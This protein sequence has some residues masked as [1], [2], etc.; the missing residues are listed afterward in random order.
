MRKPISIM[1]VLFCFLVFSYARAENEPSRVLDLK[2]K[3]IEVQNQGDL[4]IRG[5]VACSKINGYGSYVPLENLKIKNG[6]RLLMYFEPENYF[7][8][9][10]K[11]KYEILLIEDLLVLNE[12]GDIL[13][14]REG[15]V[16]YNYSST[17][18]MLDLFIT[19]AI[20]IKGLPAGRYTFKAVLN[21]KLKSR[22]AVNTLLFEV[23]E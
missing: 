13:W 16:N 4:G 15:A 20:E 5:I 2:E 10:N 3:I 22:N 6:S 8:K 12:K 14:G 17:Q 23:V 21:D 1:A 18:P 19:N 11:G 7:T 9:K